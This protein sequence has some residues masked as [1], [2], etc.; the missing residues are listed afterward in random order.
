[1]NVS[2][3]TR[4]ML[5]W[6][7]AGLEVSVLGG[8]A[9][10]GLIAVLGGFSGMRWYRYGNLFSVG[11]YP[12]T[13]LDAGFGYWSFAGFALAFLYFVALG[14]AFALVFHSRKRGVAPH[15]AGVAYAL[16]LFIAGDRL[17]W[18]SWSPYLVIY[19]NPSHLMWGHVV[20][21]AMLGWL[22]AFREA[23]DARDKPEARNLETFSTL[24][25]P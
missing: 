9:A 5:R 7:A 21:G 14:L 12:S 15:L 19:G 16:A 11:L 24:D 8:L 17:W 13:A 23:R 25:P 10:L 20:F 1:M 18:Q 2:G 22:P 3:S 4:N 6:L